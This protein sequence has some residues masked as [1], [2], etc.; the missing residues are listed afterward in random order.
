M[1]LNPGHTGNVWRY[2]GLW[3]WGICLY[4]YLVHGVQGHASQRVP[5]NKELISSKCQTVQTP[6]C[7]FLMNWADLFVN[8]E[9]SLGL[10]LALFR[11]LW[12]RARGLLSCKSTPYGFLW[13]FSIFSVWERNKFF[14]MESFPEPFTQC[15]FLP[16]TFWCEKWCGMFLRRKCRV[17]PQSLRG[18]EPWV[19]PESSCCLHLH[20][21][22]WEERIHASEEMKDVAWSRPLSYLWVLSF[23]LKNLWEF[24][25]YSLI[26]LLIFIRLLLLILFLQVIE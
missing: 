25:F 22:K 10:L 6:K 7:T 16:Y 15:L 14:P 8:L 4:R 12:K 11:P 13:E 21:H 3:Q 9:L 18:H 1:V 20:P 2:F 24:L 19:H 26:A 5:S 17:G 23:Y